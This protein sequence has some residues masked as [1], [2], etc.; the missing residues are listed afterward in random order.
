MNNPFRA[1]TRL[2]LHFATLVNDQRSRGVI[3]KNIDYSIK[4]GKKM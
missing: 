1:L 2:F 3:V 4:Y